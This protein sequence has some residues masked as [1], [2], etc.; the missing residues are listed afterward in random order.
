MADVEALLR[1]LTLQEKAALTA[2]EDMFSLVAVDRVGIPKVRV[3][4]GPA[5]AKWMSG[6]GIG[7]D[8]STWIPCESAIGA[9]WDPELAERLARLVAGEARDRGCRGLLAPTV[10][11]HRSPLAG[12][13]FE[14]FSED[15]LLS[16]RLAVGYVRGVQAQGVFATVKHFVGNEAETERTSISSVIDERTLRELYLLPF[17]LAVREG[18]ALGIMT[19]YNR[20]NGTWVTEQRDLLL[21]VL[22]DEWGFEG[23]VMTDWH[24]VVSAAESLGAGLDLEM[25]GPG[26]GLG[27]HVVANVEAGLVDEADLDAAVRRL[28]TALDRIGALDEPTP[29]VAPQPPRAQDVAL[30]R[31][32]SADATVLLTNNGVLP[33]DT[34]V[35]PRVAV[36]GE[37]GSRS[38]M[39]GGGSAQLLPHRYASPVEALRAVLGPDAVSYERGVDINRAPAR[40]G[41]PAL[42]APQ[43]FVVTVHEGDAFQGEPVATRELEDLLFIYNPLFSQAYPEG[44]WSARIS[45]DVVPETDGTRRLVLVNSSPARVYLDGRL[46][47]DGTD[48]D[49]PVLSADTSWLAGEDLFADVELT[50]G[51]PVRLV[52]EYVHS[53]APVGAFRV[54]VR[55]ADPA[56]LLERA[57]T[58]AAAAD[59]AVVFVGTNHE[60]E[61]EGFDRTSFSLPAGQDELVERVA[62]ANERTVVVVNAGTAVDLPWADDVAAVLQVWFGGQEMDGAVADVLVGRSEPGG[63]LPI[64][65]P[66]RLEHTPS[67]GNFPGENGEVRYGE[68]LFMGYRGFEQ[69]AIVP[70][71]A[72]GHGLSYTVCQLAEPELT[73]TTFRAGERLTVQVPVTNTG[74]RPGSEV[75]QLYVAPRSPRLV[76]PIKELKGFAKARLAPGETQVV[77]IVLDDRSFAYWDG[78]HP[79]YDQMRARV[80][81][82]VESPPGDPGGKPGW[83]VDPGEYDLLVGTSTEQIAF[84]VTITVEGPA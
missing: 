77:E 71:F 61:S 41:G 11:L 79:D 12:R 19:A 57:V 15:P 74:D 7:G 80:R 37:L 43:G 53:G 54:G 34:A 70:R 9:T 24:A 18:G 36:I 81:S 1:A 10:N 30:V 47:L 49:W 22:R 64:T 69:R 84:R 73:S 21:G 66:V 45:G 65:I 17:E 4:D 72:F 26:R 46:V 82:H 35:A 33:L 68:G 32:A 83:R 6:I 13:D 55:D 42:P 62:A 39:G 20:L 76:R 75:V 5:G 52:V 2:G 29:P 56:V 50:Q 51:V 40:V 48:R 78:G 60:H 3:T 14:C 67:H 25:P 16:G 58:A 27:A 23:L 31:A 59:V 38:S 63:R 8:P 44:Q 28:L